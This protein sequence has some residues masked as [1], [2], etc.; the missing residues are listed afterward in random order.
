MK[1]LCSWSKAATTAPLPGEILPQS[2][3]SAG[4]TLGCTINWMGLFALGMLFPTMVV[5]RC[6]DTPTDQMTWIVDSSVFIFQENLESFCFLIFLVFC[7]VCGLYVAF[8][9]PETKNRTVLEITAEFERMHCKD[10]TSQKKKPEQD[11]SGI[12]SCSTKFWFTQE[13]LLRFLNRWHF[14]AFKLRVSH[15]EMKSYLCRDKTLFFP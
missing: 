13:S 15:A 12:K 2:F 14:S 1:C 4:Y 5:R 10:E 3:K 7:L 9:V 11:L 6:I 8:N